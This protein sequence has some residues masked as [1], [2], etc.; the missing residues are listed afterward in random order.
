MKNALE[1]LGIFSCLF[2]EIALNGSC[3]ILRRKKN[4][5]E[6]RENPIVTKVFPGENTENGKNTLDF[7]VCGESVFVFRVNLDI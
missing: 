3:V 1:Y 6:G 2:F 4:L 7:R 5:N